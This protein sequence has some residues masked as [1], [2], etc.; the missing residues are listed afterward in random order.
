[1]REFGLNQLFACGDGCWNVKGF[2]QPAA[3]AATKGEGVLV[4]S[5]A[6]AVGRI[7]GSSAFA[8]RYTKR[9]GPIGNYA[10]N[11]Y[12]SARLVLAAITQAARAKGGLPTR[13]DVVAALRRL[14]YQ[15]IAYVRPVEWDAKGDNMAAVIFLNVVEGDRFKEVGEITRSDTP[16]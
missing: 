1:M 5:A 6:P 9:F 7:P 10:V 13:E 16:N 2:I 14:H 12:D 8:E 11:S 3:G 4:L 15:G